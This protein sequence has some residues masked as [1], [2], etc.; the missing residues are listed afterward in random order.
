MYLDFFYKDQVLQEEGLDSREDTTWT[1]FLLE[2]S[3]WHFLIEK[4]ALAPRVVKMA[5][6]VFK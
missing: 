2:Y 6:I 4:E 5:L 1:T 3:V